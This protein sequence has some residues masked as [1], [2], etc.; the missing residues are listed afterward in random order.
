ME[1]N[2]HSNDTVLDL[3]LETTKTFYWQAFTYKFIPCPVQLYNVSCTDPLGRTLTVDATGS[4][5]GDT[6][7]YCGD[8]IIN[9]DKDIRSI[10]IP[11]TVTNFYEGLYQ[12]SV[13]G[14]SR[15][16]ADTATLTF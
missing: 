2:G 6:L 8:F 1:A 16:H 13:I 10:D 12:I 15:D 9:L 3:S 5:T 7:S 11:S 4:R 14:Y